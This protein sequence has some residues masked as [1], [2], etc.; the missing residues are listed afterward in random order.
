MSIISKI[1]ETIC[2][3]CLYGCN[4]SINTVNRGDFLLRKIEYDNQSAINQGRLCARGN[5]AN[6]IIDDKKRLTSPLFNNKKIDWVI[7]LSQIQHQLKEYSGKEIAIT[8]DN[9][10]TLE[11]L[12]LIVG[13]A[14]AL[15]VDNIA[16]SYLEPETFFSYSFPDVKYA[17]LK[18]IEQAKVILVIGDIFSKIPLLSKPVLDAKYANRNNRLYCIDSVKTRIAGFANKFIHVKPGTEPLVVLGLIGMMSKNAKN[19]LGD[20]N[21]N[22]IRKNLTTITEIC[23][24]SLN[25][26]EE[27]AK[28]L[29]TIPNGVIFTS[30]NYAKTD[31]PLLL[32]ALSQ[33]L[34]IVTRPEMKFCAPALSAIPF[35]KVKFGEL[36]ESVSQGKIKAIINFGDIFPDYYPSVSSRLQNLKLFVSTTTKLDTLKRPDWILPVPSLLEKSGTV[37]TLWGKSNIKSLAEPV[38]GSKTISEIIEKIAPDIELS[39]KIKINDK[40]MLSIDDVIGRTIEYL[41]QK[42]NIKD[43]LIVIGEESAFGYRGILNADS[44]FI[45][46]HPNTA[47]QMGLKQNESVKLFANNFDKQFTIDITNAVPTN[48][49]SVAVD[50]Q[51]NRSLFPMQIDSLTKD[52]IITPA[53][54][55]ITKTD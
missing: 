7:A 38:N 39:S 21:F 47:R 24:I 2:P 4:L 34:Q 16:R 6:T 43:E 19:I 48:T 45:K 31:D 23:G 40:I 17:E 22:P 50:T 1:T 36:L 41:E 42:K 20:K 11:E 10:N 33:L 13:F 26:I 35:G 29:L 3:F 32:S 5:L 49:V 15:K 54:G 8:F 46:I 30:V 37:K 18:D 44:D 25:D 14:N 52:V 55:N 12:D 28:A 9:N 53:K 51:E 27:I